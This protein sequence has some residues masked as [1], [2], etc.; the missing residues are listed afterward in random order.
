L[1]AN[2][3]AT[4]YFAWRLT[5]ILIKSVVNGISF[6]FLAPSLIASQTDPN[7]LWGF[8]PFGETSLGGA[9]KTGKIK[10][11]LDPN[12]VRP[13]NATVYL[14]SGGAWQL[15]PKGGTVSFV[16]DNFPMYPGPDAIGQL[17]RN[18]AL[19]RYE[20]WGH[21]GMAQTG[22]TP[23]CEALD[24]AVGSTLFYRVVT[25][26]GPPGPPVLALPVKNEVGGRFWPFVHEVGGHRYAFYS[27][28][29]LACE[30]NHDFWL[31]QQAFSPVFIGNE[32]LIRQLQ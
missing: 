15:V 24:Q 17:V 8:V 3:V 16:P 12:E 9:W 10:I 29:D 30:Q 7:V 20:Q 31:T 26:T 4:T 18:T 6:Q 14:M 25:E 22:A 21:Q 1:G 19:S 23:G 28:T 32:I 11:V 13:V 5:P 27:S 2:T